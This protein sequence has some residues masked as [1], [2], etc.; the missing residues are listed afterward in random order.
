MDV[1]W[2]SVFLDVP[3]DRLDVAAGFWTQVSGTSVGTPVGTAEEFLPLEAVPHQA[4]L[5]LQRTSGGPPACH[6]DLYVEDVPGAVESSLVL[7]AARQHVL[8]ELGV[9]VMAS[10]GGM[11]F[12]LVGHRG[13]SVRM[14]PAGEAGARTVPD[15]VCLDVPPGR[16][17]A[18]CDFWAALTGWA[19][20]DED[21]HD[22]FRRVTRPPAIPFAFLLQRLAE[23]QDA[24]TA[25]LDLACEDRDAATR[26]HVGLGA[27]EVRRTEGWTVM[28]DPAGGTYCNTGRRPGAV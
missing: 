15:Q 3:P 22:E 1:R 4:S 14:T 23:E 16:Y 20:T 27:Q 21:V 5:W 6:V 11:P 26:R 7:G 8:D 17:D 24:V 2:V 10:P 25:H 18:E 9:V 12:C 13:Q 28:R 19:L